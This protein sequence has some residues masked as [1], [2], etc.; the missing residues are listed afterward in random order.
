[1]RVGA[2]RP[3]PAAE[4]GE[5]AEDVQGAPPAKG[6]AAEDNP[7]AAPA[8]GNAPRGNQAAAPVAYR[9]DDR[10]IVFTGSIVIRVANVDDAAADATAIATGAGGF[11]GADKRSSYHNR[12]EAT[13]R[14]R[15]P[16]GKFGSVVD[17]LAKQLGKP[18]SRAIDTDDVTE[19]VVDLNAKITSQQASVARTRAL[20]NQAKTISEI[21]SVEAELAKRES[22]LATLQ[23]RQRRLNDLSTLSTITATL[24]ARGAEAGRQRRQGRFPGRA[25][26]R[27]GRLPRRAEHPARRTRV[28]PAVRR[29][30]RRIGGPDLVAA[31][32]P[33][34]PPRHPRAHLGR[35]GR[36]RQHTLTLAGHPVA[37]ATGERGDSGGEE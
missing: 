3:P 10:A 2:C 11:V 34:P 8:Q 28:R 12:S 25:A 20:F 37:T 13:L 6:E 36:R 23:A 35:S 29:R 27:L 5:P 17:E 7:A 30:H 18:E 32:H 4:Q 31:A 14:L 26:D 15:V 9:A 19:E 33:P 21:V 16:A 24:L 22:E 1:V